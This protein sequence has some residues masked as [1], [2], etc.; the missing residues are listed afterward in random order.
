MFEIGDVITTAATRCGCTGTI[1]YLGEKEFGYLLNACGSCYGRSRYY[2][3][4]NEYLEEVI[5]VEDPFDAYVKDV[6]K[7]AGL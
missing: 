3:H 6:R 2:Q 7:S 1:T 4:P 5:L